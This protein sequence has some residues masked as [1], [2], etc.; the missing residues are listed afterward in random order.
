MGLSFDA[1]ASVFCILFVIVE[2]L[3]YVS[4][5]RHAGGSDIVSYTEI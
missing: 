1:G 5:N 4:I 3:A 2:K